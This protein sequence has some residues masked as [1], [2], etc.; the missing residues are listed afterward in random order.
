MSTDHLFMP[1]RRI[2]HYR[3]VVD[4]LATLRVLLVE[5]GAGKKELATLDATAADMAEIVAMSEIFPPDTPQ[6]GPVEA[7]PEQP[8]VPAGSEWMHGWVAELI[9]DAP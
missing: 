1:V 3:S 5:R 9:G 4:Y 7:L 6:P 2:E 8:L